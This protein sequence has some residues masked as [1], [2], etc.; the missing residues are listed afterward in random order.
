MTPDSYA[1]N[2]EFQVPLFVV[3][4]SAPKKLPKQTDKL[5]F[6]FVT[7]GVASAID[8][9]KMAAGDKDVTIVGGASI[10]A[11]CMSAGLADEI[12]MDIMPV[13]L[14]KGLR[15]FAEIGDKAIT[16]EKI[17]VFESTTRTHIRFRV[18]K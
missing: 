11:Q 18:I 7:D 8:Q 14:G 15:P 1:G 2:Y 13:L 4:K 17:E 6:T 5:T 9:A 16:L 3:T 12:H 10:A